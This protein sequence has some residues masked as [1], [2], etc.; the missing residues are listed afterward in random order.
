MTAPSARWL[1][2][3]D[4]ALLRELVRQGVAFR[5]IAARLGCSEQTVRTR[6]KE[7]AAGGE[8][9]VVGRKKREL[10]AAEWSLVE[11]AVIAGETLAAIG[12]RIGLSGEYIRQAL[13]RRGLAR[14]PRGRAWLHAVAPVRRAEPADAENTG[15]LRRA[16]LPPM[17]PVPWAVLNEGLPSMQAPWTR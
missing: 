5:R 2:E 11:G 14:N 17:H 4:V 7:M 3:E 16:P 10:S 12:Q 13:F 6:V 9:A 15:D 1:R 8:P